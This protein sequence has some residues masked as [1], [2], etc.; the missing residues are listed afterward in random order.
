MTFKELDKDLKNICKA[1]DLGKLKGYRTEVN[2]SIES[3][4]TAYFDTS[5]ENNLKFHFKN[6]TP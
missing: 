6:L 2:E 5:K 1:F 4:N 3:F